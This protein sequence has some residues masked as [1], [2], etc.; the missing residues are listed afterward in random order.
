MIEHIV[1]VK[2]YKSTT[3]AEKEE[4]IWRMLA[5][6]EIIPGIV[7]MQMGHNFSDRNKGYMLGLTVRFRDRVAL[8][9]YGPHPKHQEILSYMKEIGM[10]DK[11]VI[12]FEM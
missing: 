5:L 3:D 1:L 2:F 12:D 11:V 6:K 10:E 7:D 9:N 8:E 4:L